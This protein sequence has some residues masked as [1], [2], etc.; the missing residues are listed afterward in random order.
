MEITL[1]LPDVLATKLQTEAQ[2]QRRSTEEVAVELLD[3]ALEVELELQEYIPPT[4]EEVVARIRATPPN[5]AN[6]FD[7][8]IMMQGLR[9]YLQASIAAEDPN[10]PFD[11]AEW[12]QQWAAVEAEM[13][14]TTRANDL[15][16]GRG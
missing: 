10:E 11:E 4:L 13:K 3:Q 5:P 2:A 16:E 1:N 6:Q 8:R 9:E 14:A 15:A 7:E 12:K